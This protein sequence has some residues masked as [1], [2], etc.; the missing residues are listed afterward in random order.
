MVFLGLAD[1]GKLG[2][3]VRLM[4]PLNCAMMGFAVLVGAVLVPVII[5]ASFWL[6]L[7]Y[8]FLTGFT[9]TAASMA[10]NDYYDR[11]IDAI[12]EPKRPIPSGTIKPKEA[13]VFTFFL[14]VIGLVMA[15]L[16]SISCLI[17][18]VISWAISV[19]YTTVGKRSGLPGNFLV[20][21]CVSVPFIYGSLAVA[22]KVESNVLIFAS[23]AFLSVTGREITKGIV[24]VQGDKAQKIGTVAVRFGEKRAAYTAVVFFS[25]AIAL[26]PL[27]LFLNLVSFW[28][29]P[30]VAASDIGLATSSIMLLKNYSRENARKVKNTVLLW[31]LLGLIAFIVGTLAMN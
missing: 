17:L 7:A 26:S 2:G 28:F 24:D 10:I 18:A 14:T 29:I 30:S 22:G 6:N 12:N 9:L 31:F 16:T 8:G 19:S 4:R 15:Y 23:M 27:P 5:S 25:L 11:N 20:A 13:L 21:A 1:M 3:F